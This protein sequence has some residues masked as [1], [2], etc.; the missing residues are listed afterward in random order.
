[1][2]NLIEILDQIMEFAAENDLVHLF[3]EDESIKGSSVIIKDKSLVNFGSCSYLGLEHHP[4]LVDAI[5]V[6]AD[7]F[8]AQFSTS[9]AYLSIGLYQVLE[10]QLRAIFNQPV[11]VTASTTLGHM[12]ALPVLVGDDDAVIIDFQVHSSVQM[13]AQLLKARKIPLY[14]IPH[15]SMKALENKIKSLRNKHRKIWYFADGVYSMYGDVSPIKEIETL[16]NTYKQFHLYIDDAH[17]SSWTGENGLG[18]IRSQIEHHPKMTLAISLNKSFASSGGAIIFPNQELDRKVRNCGGT[19]IF[20]G[21]IQP[22]MLGAAIASV[23]LHQSKEITAHQHSL[24]AKISY[25]NKR[26]NVLGLPQY[27]AHETPIFFIPVGL[28][29]VISI[30]VQRMKHKGYFLNSAAF[31]AVPMKKGGIRFMI[32]DQLNF[33]QI[34]EMLVALQREY[35]LGLE[36]T[37]SSL[38]AVAITFK[39]SPIEIDIKK[40]QPIKFI[41]PNLS[42][43]IFRSINAIPAVD[44]DQYFKNNGNL[45]HSN[46][47]HIETIFSQ[48]KKA[49]NN[50]KFYY[51]VIKDTQNNVVLMSSYTCALLKDDMFSDAD[52]SA[53]IEQKRKQT[54]YYLS[55]KNVISGSMVTK[56]EPIYFD[57]NHPK[58]QQAFSAL[59]N[60]MQT[61]VEQEGASKLM[62]R[63]FSSRQNSVLK[64]FMLEQGLLE[65]RL[66][67]NSVV[68]NLSWNSQEEYIRRIGNKYRHNFKKEILK[69]EDQFEVRYDK[70]ISTEAREYAYGLYSYVF[71]KSYQFN[72]FKLPYH[73]FEYMYDNEHYDVICL[74]SKDL[75][76]QPVSVMFSYI[77][78]STY[79]ALIVGI[80]YSNLYHLNPYKQ[81]LYQTVKRAKAL[82]CQT[83]DLAFTAEMEKKKVGA[84]VHPVYAYVQAMEHHTDAVLALEE[85]VN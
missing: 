76:E 43:Q 58:W 39:L 71:D 41:N 44:W 26:L 81:I 52:T 28:P 75:P 42:I 8:G 51:V 85:Q 61:T 49:E 2:S 6:A 79:S 15:N 32:N 62:L 34:D 65:Y 74:Y 50:W 66:M 57:E 47:S 83:L 21:P 24:K 45:S 70:P 16:L 63:Q 1:M 36:E 55:S 35:V 59:I 7:K 84:T 80:D 5:K 11:M 13:T 22:P 33:Q 23:K 27:A 64:S 60:Q 69:F 30:I 4:Q 10:S 20:S 73:F 54:P 82:D 53:S 48:Q 12:S 29:K 25:T 68:N 9:R 17:G 19:M 37:G 67:N 46:L 78:G 31:P 56:G 77:N 38:E 72:V 14:V 40:K 3:T 18:Y